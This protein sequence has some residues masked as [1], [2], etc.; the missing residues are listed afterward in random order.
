MRPSMPFSPGSTSLVAALALLALLAGCGGGSGSAQGGKPPAGFRVYHG[1]DF[2]LAYP[3]SWGEVTDRPALSGPG[4][5]Y[6]VLAPG[7]G[8]GMSPQ[9]A[10]GRGRASG[11]FARVVDFN[12]L[13][14]KTGY[15]RWRLV[16]ERD[17]DV[18]GAEQAHEI[19]TTY[20]LSIAGGPPTPT[21]EVQVLLRT[22][23]G[24]QMDLAVRA[25]EQQFDS[26]PLR[27]VISAF[28]VR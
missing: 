13:D 14:Q 11:A 25:P 2:D 27:K 21:R 26:V 6:Q 7:P 19:E 16:G 12:K 18:P 3:S 1:P 4:H 15:P 9:I 8:R 28:R 17:I 24:V 20:L 10:L 5:Y 22:P 23:K